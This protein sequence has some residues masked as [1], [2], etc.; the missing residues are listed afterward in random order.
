[1]SQASMEP[2]VDSIVHPS[3]FSQAS[4]HAFAHALAIALR[5]NTSLVV[6][7]AGVGDKRKRWTGF[8]SVR[9]TLE[10]WGLLE[11]GTPR[12]AVS[13]DLSVRVKKVSL[14]KRR[15]LPAVLSYLEEH[16]ADLIVLATEGRNGVPRWLKPSLAEELARKSRTLS[17]FVSGTARGFVSLED[18]GLSLRRVLV[19][20]DYHPKPTMAVGWATHT[21]MLCQT[22]PIDISLLHVSSMNRAPEVSLPEMEACTWNHVQKRGEVVDAIIDTA[23]EQSADLIVMAT[24]GHNGVLDMLRGSITEQVIRRAPCP[25]LAVPAI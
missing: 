4:E 25:V 8:P 23:N 10:R 3:D 13:H 7:N 20:I 17:L 5:G 12:E 11:N 21:A 2:F 22:P 19:P 6:L 18:G 15:P 9:G 14:N 24:A 1:M 16:P